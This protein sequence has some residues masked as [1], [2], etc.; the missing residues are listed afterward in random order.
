MS[1]SDDLV[2][3]DNGATAH[4]GTT[5]SAGE[6]DLHGGGGDDQED[7]GLGDKKSCNDLLEKSRKIS[8][9]DLRGGEDREDEDLDDEKDGNEQT[10]EANH[11]EK[12]R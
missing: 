2:G 5:D 3:A 12:K 10:D 9:H 4:Q 11:D 6:H 1:S 8:W 7:E